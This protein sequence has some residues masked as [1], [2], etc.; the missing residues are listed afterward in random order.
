MRCCGHNI[1][2]RLVDIATQF[3]QTVAHDT[4]TPHQLYAPW[5]AANNTSTSPS[6]TK[7]NNNNTKKTP[8]NLQLIDKHYAVFGRNNIRPDD[9]TK[10][11][12]V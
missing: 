4:N 1:V 8:N 6:M 3:H 7:P 12:W 5:K 9:T 11:V 2:R 10:S